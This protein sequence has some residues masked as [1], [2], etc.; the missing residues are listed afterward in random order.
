M[1]LKIGVCATQ[2]QVCFVASVYKSAPPEN[3]ISVREKAYCMHK[4]IASTLWDPGHVAHV[5]IGLKLTE[6]SI[7]N[8]AVLVWLPGTRPVMLTNRPTVGKLLV[9]GSSLS[10]CRSYSP[11]DRDCAARSAW[12]GQ[13]LKCHTV[14]LSSWVMG[15]SLIGPFVGVVN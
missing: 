6:I 2:P 14:N 3:V 4:P 9:L 13:V 7:L 10:L 8:E 15:L 1:R 5:C 11:A 12:Y